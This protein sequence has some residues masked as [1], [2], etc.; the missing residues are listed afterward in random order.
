MQDF[1]SPLYDGVGL[2]VHAKSVVNCRADCA[3]VSGPN[4]SNGATKGFGFAT[5]YSGWKVGRNVS[6]GGF[7]FASI[8]D[9][10]IRILWINFSSPNS[11]SL[12]SLRLVLS[13]PKV[14]HRTKYVMTL[15]VCC[16]GMMFRLLATRGVFLNRFPWL[17][18][19]AR[20]FNNQGKQKPWSLW[21]GAVYANIA[22]YFEYLYLTDENYMIFQRCHV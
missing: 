2:E 18:N 4:P 3:V 10:F 5:R 8:R 16:R 21:S 12:I 13:R 19:L 14:I 20:I 7:A 22:K 9:N 11:A 15:V 1:F 17:S 6:N